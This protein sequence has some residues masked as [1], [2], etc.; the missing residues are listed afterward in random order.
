MNNWLNSII[1]KI[2]W[3]REFKS[4]LGLFTGASGEIPST[5]T[6][7]FLNIQIY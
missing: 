7:L 3:E 4:F 1:Q 2:I 6:E 5:T